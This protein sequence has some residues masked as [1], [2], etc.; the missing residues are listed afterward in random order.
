MPMAK[1]ATPIDNKPRSS[2]N[3]S[4]NS[5]GSE[6]GRL[7][8]SLGSVEGFADIGSGLEPCGTPVAASRPKESVAAATAVATGAATHETNVV[9]AQHDTT[10]A[11]AHASAPLPPAV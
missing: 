1:L 7:L 10:A 9:T 2:S 6:T 4:S 11:P 8:K 5:M 3:A